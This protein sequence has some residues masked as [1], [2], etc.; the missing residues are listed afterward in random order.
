MWYHIKIKAI[1][2]IVLKPIV[3]ELIQ[4]SSFSSKTPSIYFLL[5]AFIKPSDDV[6]AETILTVAISSIH[7][8]NKM[9]IISTIIISGGNYE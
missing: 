1:L 6:R 8:L 5:H 2:S 9:G 7:L 4:N 3:V